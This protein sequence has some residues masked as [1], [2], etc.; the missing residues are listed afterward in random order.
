MNR[1]K[2]IVKAHLTDLW[3]WTMLP[4]LI[5]GFSFAVNLVIGSL[6]EEVIIT[7]GLTSIYIYMMVLGIVSLGQTFPF[8]I[9]FGARRKDYFLGTAATIS[10]ISAASAV[11]LMLLG[12]VERATS[13]WGIDLRFFNVPYVTDGPLAEQFEQFWIFFNAMLHLFFL[14]FAIAAVY[15]KFGRNGLFAVFIVL[16]LALTVAFYAITHYDRWGSLLSWAQ[17]ISVLELANGMLVLT[18]L[19]VVLSYALLRKATT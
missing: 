16:G 7:G 15:R 6:V 11:V 18:L 13:Y 2:G 19:Y 14:G 17:G 9:G 1:V 10:L 12:Y 4:W 5:L 8:L 3:S